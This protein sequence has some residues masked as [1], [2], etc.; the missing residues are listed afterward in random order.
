VPDNTLA[1]H[2]GFENDVL[3]V[4]LMEVIN[5]I[6][7]RLHVTGF[8]VSFMGVSEFVHELFYCFFHLSPGNFDRFVLQTVHLFSEVQVF[9]VVE[10]HYFILS[11]LFLKV[12]IILGQLPRLLGLIELVPYFVQFILCLILGCFERV[13]QV[14][15][16]GKQ[17]VMFILQFLNHRRI[18]LLA[19]SF[20]SLVAILQLEG[21]DL[22]FLF[23]FL[24][25]CLDLPNV[26]HH[27]GFRD[28]VNSLW[29]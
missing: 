13:N 23:T 5:V 22:V 2:F 19:F 10:A 12:I 27:W 7:D 14:L 6:L 8:W 18:M 4:V 25:L 15:L 21:V 24:M 20:E 28:V 16:L 26:A 17:V 11:F 29:L 3:L 9:I 1:N